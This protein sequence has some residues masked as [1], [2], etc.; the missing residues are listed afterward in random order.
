MISA[1]RPSLNAKN[2]SF[3]IKFSRF[4][5]N[6]SIRAIKVKMEKNIR[7]LFRQN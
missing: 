7:E 5:R 1:K 4:R 6:Y 2:W 3:Q